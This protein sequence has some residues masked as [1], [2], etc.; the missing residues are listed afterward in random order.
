M[1]TLV[2][3]EVVTRWVED[4]RHPIEH[5]MQQLTDFTRSTDGERPTWTARTRLPTAPR[6]PVEIEVTKWSS[7]VVE[8][9]V[10][11]S[12]RRL[13]TWSPARERRYFEL[14]HE[15]ADYVADVLRAA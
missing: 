14:A 6:T 9:S 5:T 8:L 15:A 11:P 1:T 10:R 3:E 7:A 2:L 12:G 4:L 13:V